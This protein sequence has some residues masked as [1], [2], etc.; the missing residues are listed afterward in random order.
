MT[1]ILV[2]RER[3]LNDYGS[4]L[5]VAVTKKLSKEQI[6]ENSQPHQWQLAMFLARRTARVG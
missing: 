5:S 1:G 2:L 6:F 4:V 3:K